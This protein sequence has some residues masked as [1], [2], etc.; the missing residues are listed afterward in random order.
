VSTFGRF[1]DRDEYVFFA[2][3]SKHE[4]YKLIRNIVPEQHYVSAYEL[5]DY[6][7]TDADI[8]H[9]GE[10]AWNAA[11]NTLNMCKYNLGWASLRAAGCL[12]NAAVEGGSDT[13]DSGRTSRRELHPRPSPAR[14]SRSGRAR[15]PPAAR[16]VQSAG[17][18][19]SNFKAASWCD[20]AGESSA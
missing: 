11:L 7:L 20:P 2:V 6:P 12:R 15:T 1:A 14:P 8:L 4:R 5:D 18:D 17:C 19:A 10:A 13:P 16:R 9:R 3:D